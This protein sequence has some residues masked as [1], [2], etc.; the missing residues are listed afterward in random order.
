MEPSLFQCK[1]RDE[2]VYVKGFGAR[3]ASNGG[4][5]KCSTTITTICSF[6]CCRRAVGAAAHHHDDD[7]GGDEDDAERR[8]MAQ[9]MT[10]IADPAAQYD[11]EHENH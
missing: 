10:M 11:D 4:H 9:M 8:R 2:N 3:P 7:D 5:I 6:C 1:M